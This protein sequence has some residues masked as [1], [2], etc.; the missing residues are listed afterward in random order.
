MWGEPI[1]PTNN[2]NHPD[3]ESFINSTPEPTQPIKPDFVE[4]SKFT[5]PINQVYTKAGPWHN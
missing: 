1:I 4:S 2:K 5:E 3:E